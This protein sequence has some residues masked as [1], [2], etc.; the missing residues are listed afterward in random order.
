MKALKKK[1]K[2]ML[3]ATI[4][5]CISALIMMTVS[6][7]LDLGNLATG[8][9]LAPGVILCAYFLLKMG[10][11]EKQIFDHENPGWR[12]FQWV[13]EDPERYR[14]FKNKVLASYLL[15]PAISALFILLGQ[16]I[17][18]PV[19]AY[20]FAILFLFAVAFWAGYRLDQLLEVYHEQVASKEDT[21][22]SEVH[23]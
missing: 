12:P 3:I 20:E 17:E 10:D 9:M 8:L 6:Y 1:Y 14:K 15:T 4:L 19:F 21:D 16:A 13:K 23:R 7:I 18:I 2:K 22:V 11:V 5:S